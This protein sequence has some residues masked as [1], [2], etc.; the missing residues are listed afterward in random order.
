MWVEVDV[1][2]ESDIGLVVDQ[3]G[4][5]SKALTR[6]EDSLASVQGAAAALTST[7]ARMAESARPDEATL[8]LALSLAVEGGVVVAKGS[9]KAEASVTLVWK[10]LAAAG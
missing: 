8:E 4:G 2:Q 9:A 1:A 5:P 7:V 6:L 3:Q 10:R